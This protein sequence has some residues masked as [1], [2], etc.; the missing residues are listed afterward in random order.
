MAKRSTITLFA[1]LSVFVLA[2]T[3]VGPV[4]FSDT[5]DRPQES[6]L[7]VADARGNGVFLEVPTSQ[8]DHVELEWIHSVEKEP[9]REIYRI[10]SHHLLL[11]D[12]YLKSF[13]AGVPSDLEGVTVNEGGIV[14]TSKIDRQIEALNWVHSHE[15][16]HTFRVFFVNRSE[17]LVLQQEIPHHTFATAFVG[18]AADIGT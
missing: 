13:G 11:T 1:V 2:L 12:V 18:T 4:A 9:W 8:I 5:S 17:P 3:V 6:Q 16:D 14:H 15:T 10:N 7:I